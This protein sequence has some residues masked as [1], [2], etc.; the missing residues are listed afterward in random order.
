MCACG[1]ADHPLCEPHYDPVGPPPLLNGRLMKKPDKFAVDQ[2]RDRHIC[3]VLECLLDSFQDDAIAR[4]LLGDVTVAE[5]KK[6]LK[7]RATFYE[8]ARQSG[9]VD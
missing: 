8:A 9:L 3:D 5:A 1:G 6:W 4:D 2:A 7:S